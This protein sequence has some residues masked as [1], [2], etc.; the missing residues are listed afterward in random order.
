VVLVI[1]AAFMATDS[2]AQ[3]MQG[4][5]AK[6]GTLIDEAL[7]KGY[8]A[9]CSL[10]HEPVATGGYYPCLDIGPYRF[11]KEYEKTSAFVV[12]EK[13]KPYPI[14][15]VQNG[16]ISFLVKGPWTRDL[17]YRISTWWADE[18]EGGRAKKEGDVDESRRRSEAEKAV[19]KFTDEPAADG[20]QPTDES[21]H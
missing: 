9:K 13:A 2:G 15:E 5:P 17:E 3:E 20:S 12:L 1:A 7:A 14:G 18:I 21:R 16:D 10:E 6:L 19:K 11:I 8:G 4:R